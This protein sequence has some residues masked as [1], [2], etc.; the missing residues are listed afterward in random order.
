MEN[1]A[2]LP[3][4]SLLYQAHSPIKVLWKTLRVYHST[5]IYTSLPTSAKLSGIAALADGAEK[6]HTSGKLYRP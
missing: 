3:H 4:S 2:S 5:F 6:F 1:S